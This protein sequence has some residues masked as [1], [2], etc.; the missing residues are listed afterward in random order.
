M[1]RDEFIQRA[2]AVHG[3]KYSYTLVDYVNIKTKV[4]IVCPD[5]GVFEQTPDKHIHGK[6][7][8]PQCAG[9]V[10]LTTDLFIQKA[11]AVHGDKYDYSLVVYKN[12]RE[13]MPIICP[14][15]GVFYQSALN[16]LAGKGCSLCANNVL[17]TTDVFIQKAK[18]VH[19][20]VYDY[21]EV[22]YHGNRKPIKIVCSV[23]GGFYQIPYAHL[24][25]S[26]C[27]LCGR[28]NQSLHR[29][30]HAI[31]DKTKATWLDKYGVDNV[32]KNDDVRNRHLES[33]CSIAVNE[34][35]VATK[36]LNGSFNTSL[37]EYRLQKILVGLFGEQDVKRNY[38]SEQYPFMCDF[39]IPSRDL[40]IE[41]N[42]HWSH[43][44]HWYTDEDKN[45]VLDWMSKSKFYKNAA[46][47]FS[48]RDVK[49][50]DTAKQHE[51]NYVVFWHADLRDVYEW[52]SVG[53]PDSHDWDCEYFWKNSL[54]TV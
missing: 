11:R 33:V 10:R 52:V 53:C 19:G 48:V 54:N 13:L 22:D 2:I 4:K 21:S 5:H 38:S 40:Y 49:K 36:R 41:L 43:G 50:R 45:L 46:E 15:H 9:N 37:F 32:M 47:I 44:G 6:C 8:C 18:V 25:G 42:A 30:A 26:G 28:E 51:L 27:P 24:S 1:T 23:H 35:R 12:N 31:F 17:L 29:D 39:Y 14:E 20:D 16:H 7:G 3:S 34:K